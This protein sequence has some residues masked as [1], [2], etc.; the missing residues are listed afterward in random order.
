MTRPG[1]ALP[2]VPNSEL[3]PH[4]HHL[5]GRCLECILWVPR[6]NPNAGNCLAEET[7]PETNSDWS[8]PL[9][10]IENRFL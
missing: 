9:F 5:T 7:E 4:P 10:T 2:M 1:L 8:C 3:S 6:S